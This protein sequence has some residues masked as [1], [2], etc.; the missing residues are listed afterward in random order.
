MAEGYTVNIAS[1]VKR[2]KTALT[3]GNTPKKIKAELAARAEK[4]A[5]RISKD[6]VTSFNQHPVTKE[7]TAYNLTKKSEL[8]GGY[9]NLASFYGLEIE[10]IARHFMLFKGLFMGHKTT[11]TQS[12]TVFTVRLVFP[13]VAD[14]YAVA[15]APKGYGGSWLE[16]LEKL[17]SFAQTLETFLWTGMADGG[18]RNRIRRINGSRTGY[19]A[20]VPEMA[21]RTKFNPFIPEIPYITDIY[22]QVLGGG[23]GKKRLRDTIKTP[24]SK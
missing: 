19:A 18:K 16:K 3:T 14:F 20:Q 11:V 7:L 21:Y 4:A 1:A 22:Q 8:M 2:A 13:P 10:R 5:P 12:G 9:G 15:E 17:G 23:V 24:L 6:L